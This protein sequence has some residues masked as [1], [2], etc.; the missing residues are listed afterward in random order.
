[1]KVIA[2]G[3]EGDADLSILDPMKFLVSQMAG[4]KLRLLDSIVQRHVVD[5]FSNQRNEPDK[6]IICQAVEDRL[7]KRVDLAC[8]TDLTDRQAMDALRLLLKIVRRNDLEV[9]FSSAEISLL[10]HGILQNSCE[11]GDRS[12]QVRNGAFSGRPRGFVSALSGSTPRAR[13]TSP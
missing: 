11:E 6:M 4:L 1:M 9:E 2:K 10:T 12:P 5:T 13:R 8:R 7:C 3:S